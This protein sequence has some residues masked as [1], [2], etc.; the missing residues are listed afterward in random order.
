MSI[1]RHLALHLGYFMQTVA[2]VVLSGTF[3]TDVL[4]IYLAIKALGGF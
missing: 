4:L 1:F 2:A 3:W